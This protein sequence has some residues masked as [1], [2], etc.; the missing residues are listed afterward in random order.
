MVK[1]VVLFLLLLDCAANKMIGGSFKKTLSATA[2]TVRDHKWMWWVHYLIDF[3]AFVL[4][5][6]WKHTEKAYTAEEAS[7]NVWLHFFG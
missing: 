5:G 7:G 4:V 2:W 3:G 1:I 6:Q